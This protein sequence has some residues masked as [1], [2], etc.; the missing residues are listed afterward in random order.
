[1]EQHKTP[2]SSVLKLIVKTSFPAIVAYG[3]WQ[4]EV[5]SSIKKITHIKEVT[6]L[7]IRFG[8]W[9]FIGASFSRLLFD[10]LR[11]SHALQY[12]K[13]EDNM[14]LIFA[15]QPLGGAI[16]IINRI[17]DLKQNEN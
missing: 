15:W 12:D 8:C 17:F 14:W 2:F 9:Y 4:S 10:S 6:P 1:M 3:C 13:E 7:F 5:L 16:T 11:A